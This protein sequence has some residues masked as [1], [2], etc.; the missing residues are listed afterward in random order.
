MARKQRRQHEAAIPKPLLVM[1]DTVCRLFLTG[2]VCES[3]KLRTNLIK[4]IL[5]EVDRNPNNT[6]LWCMLG[7]VYTFKSKMMHCYRRALTTSP[8]DPEANAEIAILYA[9]KR[10]RRYA[11]HFD[12]ALRYCRGVDIEDSIIYSALEAARLARDETRV[13]RALRFGRTRFPDCVLFESE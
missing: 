7:D 6:R 12:R 2:H 5:R 1:A 10:D 3:R 8:N 13:K 4:C 9:G 11:T